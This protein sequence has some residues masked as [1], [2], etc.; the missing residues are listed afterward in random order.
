VLGAFSGD[1]AD[2]HELLRRRSAIADGGDPSCEGCPYLKTSEWPAGEHSVSW[3][4]ITHFNTCNLECEYCWLQWADYSPRKPGSKDP[5]AYP[6]F[7]IVKELVDTSLLSP[8]ALIDW[9]GGGES[10]LLPDFDD[11]FYLL[12]EYGTTQW[13][14]TNA[15]R[16]P[17][18]LETGSLRSPVRVLCS[19]DAG[20]PETYVAMKVRDRFAQVLENL[21][22]YSRAGAYI[23]VKYIVTERN[24]G[25]D[26]LDAFF[27]VMR[28]LRPNEIVADTDLRYP[29]AK[30][31]IVDALGYIAWRCSDELVPF[32]FGSTGINHD[33]GYDLPA[34][35]TIAW[36]RFRKRSLSAVI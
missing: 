10:T 16:V 34:R 5:K 21:K 12:D 9:G 6:I 11:T 2:L 35:A 1:P 22:I 7:P 33:R 30:P 19:L 18:S 25:L 13:L 28:D 8:K 17:R 24:A 36:H 23:A 27:D 32:Q 14:H 20:R 26:E 3:L 15:V 31:E 4:G 29:N